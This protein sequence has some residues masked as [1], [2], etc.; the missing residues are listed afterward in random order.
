MNP[1]GIS[2][3]QVGKIILFYVAKYLNIKC[4]KNVNTQQQ[5]KLLTTVIGSMQLSKMVHRD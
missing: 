5:E 3:L 2:L 1:G 4:T